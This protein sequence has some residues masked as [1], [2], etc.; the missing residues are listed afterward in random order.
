MQCFIHSQ[1]QLILLYFK[2][3][4]IK[5]CTCNRAFTEKRYD[6]N[7]SY[8]YYLLYKLPIRCFALHFLHCVVWLDGYD[9][10][11]DSLSIKS[12]CN[13]QNRLT[14]FEILTDSA[15]FFQFIIFLGQVKLK[16]EKCNI[17]H[18]FLILIFHNMNEWKG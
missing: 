18:N 2:T 5:N 7:W 1:A 10:Y 13:R 8:F 3:E 9:P 11:L 17:K 16:G 12:I 6:Q 4:F 15:T 14:F